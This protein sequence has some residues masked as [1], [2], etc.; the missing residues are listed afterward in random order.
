VYLPA[1]WLV[2]ER[3]V[4]DSDVLGARWLCHLG[5]PRGGTATDSFNSLVKSL[6]NPA[7]KDL[8]KL[9]VG[10]H[11]MAKV[12]TAMMK[13][14]P[15]ALMPTQAETQELMR[16]QSS[17]FQALPQVGRQEG[18]LATPQG[19]G[20]GAMP[21]SGEAPDGAAA[22]AEACTDGAAEGEEDTTAEKEKEREQAEAPAAEAPAAEDTPAE[23]DKENEEGEQ[24]E[25]KDDQGDVQD[26]QDEPEDATPG[27]KRRAK[28]SSSKSSSKRAKSAEE[29]GTP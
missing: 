12:H 19:D 2:V 6:I 25:R 16:A 14:L 15:P 10:M 9:A 27:Q 29:C 18:G 22:D 17:M 4:N 7:E 8:S 28:S 23:K 26:D 3:T 20:T 13:L 21:D 1:G 5:M 11:L 24:S